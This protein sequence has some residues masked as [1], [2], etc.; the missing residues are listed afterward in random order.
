MNISEKG[1]L[2]NDE[3]LSEISGGVA[4]EGSY[5]VSTCPVPGCGG[6]LKYSRNTRYMG[7]N[8]TL[9]KCNK[10]NREFSSA[11]ANGTEDLSVN[12]TGVGNDNFGRF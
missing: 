6:E 7:G 10:C 9:Y 5:K 4:E 12:Y 11:Q 1:K 2:I 8:L 3:Q